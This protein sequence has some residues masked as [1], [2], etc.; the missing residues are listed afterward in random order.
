MGGDAN[1]FSRVL[2]G[3]PVHAAFHPLKMC[4]RDRQRL[5][6]L[7]SSELIRFYY[8]TDLIGSEVGAAAKN[9]VG[10][11]A[12]MLDGLDPV[13]YTHLSLSWLDGKF[14]P[15]QLPYDIWAAQYFTECQYSG[16]YG[17]W[18]YTSSGSVPGIQGG[19]DMNECYQDYPKAIKEKGLNGF[20]K[21]TPAP[22]PEPAKTADVYYRVRTKADGWLPEVKNLEDYAGFTGDVYKRQVLEGRKTLGMLIKMLRC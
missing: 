21:P 9:V 16:Q 22:E 7:L 18:Q 1:R 2:S 3:D 8:G 6:P 12:G 19:V 4:I 5:V 13:S 14:Y 20:D 10:I 17:M 15:D 11:A